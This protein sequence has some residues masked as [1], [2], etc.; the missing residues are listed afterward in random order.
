MAGSISVSGISSGLDT[1]N[2][3][4]ELMELKRRPLEV[5]KAKKDLYEVQLAELQTL[6]LKLLSF[7]NIANSFSTSDGFSTKMASFANTNALDNN[8]VV[9]V[10]VSSSAVAGSY[11][12]VVNSLA[13]AE[14]EI[15]DG[16]A[17]S[18]S[19]I[20]TGN[21]SIQVGSSFTNISIDSTNNTLSG[22]KDAI[23][24][25][26]ADVTATILD[27]GSSDS[28]YRLVIAS[29]NI[30][31]DNAL[32]I[33][34]TGNN[35]IGGT[36]TNGPI[37]N[38]SESQSAS[39]ASFTLDGISI[40]R[41]SNTITDIIDGA[42][43]DLES[44]GSGT[45]TLET[46]ADTVKTNIESFISEY[47]DVIT[48]I[49]DQLFLDT[50]SG[51]TGVLFG[52]TTVIDLQSTMRNIITTQIPGLS[53]TYTALAQVG[54]TTDVAGL[55][56]ID[57]GEL[58]D[59]IIADIDAVANLF[60]GA[61]SSDTSGLVF[62]GFTEDTEGGT[63]T[64]QISDGQVQTAES[65]T[66]TFTDSEGSGN[67]YSGA[68]GA[69]EDGLRFGLSS[70][71]DGSKGSIT[72]SLGVAAQFNR[73]LDNLTDLSKQGPL[74]SEFDSLTSN[75]TLIEDFI[76]DQEDILAFEEDRLVARFAAL[77]VFVTKMQ[78]QADFLTQITPG[79]VASAK[80]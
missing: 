35:I 54:I 45:I 19:T 38:F 27:D 37:L 60:I 62:V 70:L 78:F 43:I 42:T 1:S 71:T 16:F 48:F 55:L 22:L 10:T 18:S 73:I 49:S 66:T 67:Y 56:E 65:G 46:D 61:G 80:A 57:D 34:H 75:I 24:A 72:L 9:D 23:N 15:A 50:E 7:Q 14:K 11:S 59:A 4:S 76:D 44:V 21:F 20:S 29:N 58:T 64:V 36:S 26:G 77:E 51:E 53:D 25:S 39:D 33:T 47:N 40:T 3:V 12:L 8:T 41:S 5:D 28:P 69:S 30:G 13:K 32:T 31:A 6:N 63:Y 79:L 17:S 68:S 52:N 2:I 74:K